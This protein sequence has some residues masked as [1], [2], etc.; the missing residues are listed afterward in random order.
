MIGNAGQAGLL[1]ADRAVRCT[2][3]ARK[4]PPQPARHVPGD[5]AGRFMAQLVG[6]LDT[7][8]GYSATGTRV[9]PVFSGL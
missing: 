4:Q 5:Q 9:M 1:H 7:Y 6:V 2:L 3:E 8:D